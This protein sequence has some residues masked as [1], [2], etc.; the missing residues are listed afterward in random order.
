MLKKFQHVLL[1]LAV[2]GAVG[3]A[4]AFSLLGPYA[5]WQAPA[6]GYDPLGTDIGGPMNL[7]EEYRWNTKTITY[8]FD[9]S[10]LNY[11][12]AR[13]KAEVE[14]A[15]AILNNLPAVSRMSTN[16]TEFPL[17]TRRFNYQASALGLLDMKSYALA[18]LMEELG[19]ASPERY[20]W[21]LRDRR[22]ISGVT[23]YLV[24]RRNFDPVTWV[25]SS[26]VNGELYTYFIGE[27]LLVGGGS[28]AD[29]VE[30][31]VDPLAFTHRAVVSAADG[32]W[33]GNLQYGEFFT[34]LTRDDA[35]ALRYLYRPSNYNT[36]NLLAGTTGPGAGGNCP[37]CP[38]GGGTN[39]VPTN[40]VID[41]ALRP[42]V[43]KITFQAARYDSIF[44]AFIVTTNTTT[45]TYATNSTLA[46]QTIE[47]VLT[48]PDI[49][50]SAEDIGLDSAG[51]P[52]AI[53]RTATSGWANNDALNG[54][55]AL[56]GPG[57]VQPQVVI[58]FNKIGP[59]QFNYDPYF[60]D[61]ANSFAG[62]LW[63]SFDG[64]TNPPVV[65]PSGISIQD[66]EQQVL[67]GAR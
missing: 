18:F 25:P 5:A 11:F 47:R 15:I 48:R 8:G 56:N 19:P 52:V 2:V 62:F 44:G 32:F 42:G 43:D 51:N 3:S 45:D 53:S 37:W 33:G 65:Y 58:T 61:E 35:G 36:E 7:G 67:G 29:A 14:K 10:F 24:I 60:L 55:A 49:L 39:A 31:P 34:G 63:G 12:G 38:V 59:Y 9:E 64:T 4:S 22:V 1:A 66:L 27:Y 6:I 54:Q 21:T 17:D 28:F 16:L 40:S 30:V 20:V 57:V 23:N 46:T 41:L 26:Y 13:G 50:F